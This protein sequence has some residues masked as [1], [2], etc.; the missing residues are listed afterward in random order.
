MRPS[1]PDKD[2]AQALTTTGAIEMVVLPGG[3]F[4]MGSGDADE[5]DQQLHKVFVSPLGDR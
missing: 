5:P 4:E 1:A 2:V 3:W